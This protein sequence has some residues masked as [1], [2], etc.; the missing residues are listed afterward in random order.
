MTNMQNIFFSFEPAIFLCISI[1][2]LVRHEYGIFSM[3]LEVGYKVFFLMDSCRQDIA[4]QD[5]G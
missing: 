2:G 5:S 3:D 4:I 1:K